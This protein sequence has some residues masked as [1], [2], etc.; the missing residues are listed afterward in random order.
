MPLFLMLHEKQRSAVLIGI[1][2][3]CIHLI[4]AFASRSAGRFA[5]KFKTVAAPL[6]ITLLS[7]FVFGLVAGICYSY[8]WFIAAGAL[9][10]IIYAIEN[11]RKPIGISYLTDNI[12]PTVLSSSLSFQSLAETLVAA[13]I[14][15]AIG[16]I[17]DRYSIG[18]GLIAVSAIMLIPAVL[19]RIKVKA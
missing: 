1:I 11:I 14:A 17:A 9:F 5:K 2:F 15:P 6:N 10:V 16:W 4:T 13:G 18:W 3:F 8:D 12:D 7:G 19:V